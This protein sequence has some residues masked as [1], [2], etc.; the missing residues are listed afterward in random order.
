M[1][2]HTASGRP[3]PYGFDCGYQE[4]T[5]A[6]DVTVTL[7]REHGTYHVRAHDHARHERLAWT[8]YEMIGPARREYDRLAAKYRHGAG[9]YGAWC[10]N[11]ALCRDKGY[12][13]RE[14]SCAD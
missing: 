9:V 11:P 10:V 12:C 4:T 14:R 6:H 7:Y 2:T 8:R 13:P 5:E 3:T 1:N